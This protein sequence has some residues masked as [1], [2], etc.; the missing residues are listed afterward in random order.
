MTLI[1]A[2]FPVSVPALTLELSRR[3]PATGAITVQKEE[4]DPKR[5]G[6]IAVDVWN[7]HWCKTAT[8]R[9]FKEPITVTLTAPLNPGVEIGYTPD[10]RQSESWQPPMKR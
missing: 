4:V 5:V 2:S 9:V 1:A 8:L 6:G 3:D 10:M 7:F